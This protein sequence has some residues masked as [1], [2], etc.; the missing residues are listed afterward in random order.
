MFGGGLAISE[1]LW[2][3][4]FRIFSFYFL[5]ETILALVMVSS[6]RYYV[7]TGMTLPAYKPFKLQPPKTL[8]IE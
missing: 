6:I 5:A 8:Q 7:R 4:G 3:F 2:F 1:A